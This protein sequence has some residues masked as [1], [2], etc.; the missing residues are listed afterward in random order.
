MYE[1]MVAPSLYRQQVSDKIN[2]MWDDTIR[3][4]KH[5]QAPNRWARPKKS[6]AHLFPCRIGRSTLQAAPA[7]H[8]VRSVAVHLQACDGSR[9]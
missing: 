3:D 4:L 7:S 1:I 2:Q 9:G 6:R 5:L 8:Q